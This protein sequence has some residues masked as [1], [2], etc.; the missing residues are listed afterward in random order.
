MM[1]RMIISLI[2]I[3]ST[4]AIFLIVRFLSFIV[5]RKRAEIHHRLGVGFLAQRDFQ[6]AEEEFRKAISIEPDHAP[7]H[8]NLGVS[9]MELKKYCEAEREFREAI[10]ISPDFIAA[11]INLGILLKELDRREEA[12]AELEKALE[13]C[14]AHHRYED[15]ESA[16]ELLGKL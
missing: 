6:R 10:R 3:I 13:L 14:E 1:E 2:L 11:Y 4:F 9:L 16:E 12:R 8:V 7:A 15:A 5:K